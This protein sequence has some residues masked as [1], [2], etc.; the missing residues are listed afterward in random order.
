MQFTVGRPDLV[1]AINQRWLLKFWMRNVR[2]DAVPRWQTVEAENLASVKANLSFVDVIPGEP[3]RYRVRFH[4]DTI[5]KVYGSVDCRGKHLDEIIPPQRYGESQAT[6]SE[7]LRGRRP[8]YTIH[9][10]IDGEGRLVHYERLL[11]P[12]GSDGATVDRIL[13]SF[14]FICADGAFDAQKLLMKQAQPPVL[15]L[16]ATIEV[17]AA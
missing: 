3:A 5:A 4:G 9:D 6:Y 14:E 15:K 8:V 2:Q 12:F 13:A 11:L 17:P 1:R 16:A 10:L 7:A